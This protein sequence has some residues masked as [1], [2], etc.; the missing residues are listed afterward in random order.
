[1]VKKILLILSVLAIVTVMIGCG[2]KEKKDVTVTFWHLDTQD[3]FKAAWQAQVD[4]FMALNPHVKIEITVLE[5]EAFK[6]KVATMMQSGNPPDLF[7]SWGG[8]VM[9]QYAEAGL[10][11]DVTKE[12][13][14]G[15]FSDTIGAGPLGVYS[16]K[17]KVYGIPY[18]MGAVGIWYNKKMFADNGLSEFK[19]W[20]ELIE[21]CKKLK[22]AG[23]TPIALGEQDKWP[24]HFWFGYL[25]VRIAG[26]EAIQKAY[27]REGKFTDAPFVEAFVKLKE[28]VDL[29]AFQKGFLG[30]TY[31]D[32]ASLT[33]NRKAAMEL[34]GQWAP[35]VQEQQTKDKKGLG[36]DLGF[37]AF[38]AVEGGA[39]DITDVFGG[40]D[41]FAFGVNAPDE[42]IDFMKF[43]MSKEQYKKLYDSPISFIPT[44]KGTSEWVQDPNMKAVADATSKAGFYQ[45]YFDQAFPPAVG[46]AILDA[47]QGICAGTKTPE[48]AAGIIQKAWDEEK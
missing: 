43:L 5:N 2:P 16:Y 26:G 28:L 40:G 45:L 17:G 3:D 48:E 15:G 24:G 30:A 23:I 6:Q 7:R 10:L 42:A 46:G 4:E 20:N 11:R 13:K 22:A 32:Q 1:M 44:V 33:A 37:M 34:M 9:N 35:S 14:K 41:G 31:N 27:A 12:L 39:G 47:V 25:A 19:T 21:G 36:S 29:G 38:P 8:G 18:N